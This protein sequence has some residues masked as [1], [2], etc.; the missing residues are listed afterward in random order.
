M[1]SPAPLAAL[2]AIAALASLSALAS[3]RVCVRAALVAPC[4]SA[5]V[6]SWLWAWRCPARRRIERRGTGEIGELGEVFKKGLKEKTLR[7]IR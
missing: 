2:A 4:V 5:R 7:A 6:A 3:L 1:R